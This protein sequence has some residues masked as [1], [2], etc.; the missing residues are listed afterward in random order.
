LAGQADWRN[1]P[2]WI[3][4][5]RFGS[6]FLAQRWPNPT[7]PVLNIIIIYLY[8]AYYWAFETYYPVTQQPFCT[9]H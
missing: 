2:R 1:G 3:H 6:S 4:M 9:K 7:G 8:Y 5:G